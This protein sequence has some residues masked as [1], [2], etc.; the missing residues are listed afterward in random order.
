MATCSL[1]LDKRV[2]LKNNSFNLSIRVINGK[3]QVY[4]NISKMTEKQ[5]SSIFDKKNMGEKSVE[6]RNQCQEKVGKV[7]KILSEMKTFDRKLLKD[8]FVNKNTESKSEIT[9]LKLSDLF[10]RYIEENNHLS[11][12]T[13]KH[14]NYSKNVFIKDDTEI[15]VNEITKDFLLTNEKKRLNEGT[16][17]SSI[18]SNLR[19]LRTVIN[20]FKTKNKII[21]SD[22]VYPFSKNGYQ[23]VEYI[24]KKL[25]LSNEEIHR[26]VNTTEFINDAEEFSKN[27]WELLYRCN[28]INFADLLRLR[29]DQQKGKYFIFFRKKT[30]NTRK[31][32]KQEV[33]L[34]INEKIEIL[35]DKVGNKESSFVLGLL[36]DNYTEENF[37]YMNRKMRKSIN[38]SLGELSNRLNLSI[39]LKL[40]TSRD[41]Y[42]SV[43]KRSGVSIDKI[44]EMLSH[45]NTKVT[46]H[47]LDSMDLDMVR[48]INEN[49]I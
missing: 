2:K 8:R 45:S 18:N 16:T 42:A 37:D 29:W 40:K 12:R 26:V 46:K 47:Y 23:I 13:K 10:A 7:E 35:L 38:K 19:D 30:E 17:I 15:L 3:Q 44:S 20:Y 4:L 9:S 32:L 34:A 22:Y 43:L 6:F 39:P 27:I 14:M 41:S 24:P 36:N 48:E 5:Y 33:V 31:N 21:P 28:G 49:L 1:V 25:V 11:F